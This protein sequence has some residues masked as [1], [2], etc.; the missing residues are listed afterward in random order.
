MRHVERER[1]RRDTECRRVNAHGT[2]L[3]IRQQ[4]NRHEQSQHGT[5]D[6]AEEIEKC[7]LAEQK[8]RDLTAMHAER[9]QDG[10][11]RAALSYCCCGPQQ[12][13]KQRKQRR[14]HRPNEQQSGH[15]CGK[16]IS[17]KLLAKGWRRSVG[18]PR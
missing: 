2:E 18:V 4:R 8:R 9:P 15:P 6:Y 16:R 5:A 11:L 7:L 14:R 17:L 10:E 3:Q 13:T 1:I 12:A